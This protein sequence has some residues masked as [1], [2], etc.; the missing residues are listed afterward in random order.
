MPAD[1]TRERVAFMI[2][3]APLLPPPGDVEVAV[4]CRAL[5]AAWDERDAAIAGL[6]WQDERHGTRAEQE[7]E[8]AESDALW[9]EVEAAPKE[10]IR[11]ELAEAG[12]DPDEAGRKGSVLV[13]AIFRAQRA[14]RD[15]ARLAEVEAERDR[16]AAELAEAR[17]NIEDMG[18]NYNRLAVVN[19]GLQGKVQRAR[20]GLARQP[21]ACCPNIECM[22]P[23]SD[24]SRSTCA[25][26]GAA[27]ARQE[28]PT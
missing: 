15:A 2:R 7:A 14:E 17:R 19:A 21:V 22:E 10:Q 26:C 13:R 16:L 20:A 24:A 6:A 27:L 28:D 4:L 11:A 25:F 23:V 8:E 12:I 9:A 18:A 1:L 3:C 5:L